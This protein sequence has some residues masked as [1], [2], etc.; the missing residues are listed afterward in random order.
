MSKTSCKKIL[1]LIG[2]GIIVVLLMAYG[3]FRVSK[4]RDFQFFGDLVSHVETNEKVVAL[5]FDDAPT[6]YTDEVLDILEEKDI[7]A[8]FY[9][10]GESAEKYPD[11]LSAIIE[12]GHE[13]GNHSYSHEHFLLKSR[14]FISNE[15]EMTNQILREAGYTGDITFRPPYGKKLFGLPWYLSQ[16]DII[17]IMWDVEPDTYFSGDAENITEYTLKNVEPGS[18]ILMHPFCEAVCVADREALPE[19]IDE[20]KADGYSFLT[21]SEFLEYY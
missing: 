3:L 16:N 8:T 9:V 6:G 13:V 4:L 14:S 10:I 20:L 5:T 18:I 17:T 11:Q 12:G 7:K 2:A 21:V 15:I 19:I 1:P